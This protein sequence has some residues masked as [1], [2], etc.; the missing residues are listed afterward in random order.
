MSLLLED[1][2]KFAMG[3]TK[4]PIPYQ[5]LHISLSSSS[6]FA[7]LFAT[8]RQDGRKVTVT[9]LRSA[10]QE[11]RLTLWIGARHTDVRHYWFFLREGIELNKIPRNF[12]VS[13]S[14]EKS[15]DFT[16]KNSTKSQCHNFDHFISQEKFQQLRIFQIW[17]WPLHF[18]RN[19]E[20]KS[21]H[22]SFWTKSWVLLQ[23]AKHRH[24][25]RQRA[26][27]LEIMKRVCKA[28]AVAFFCHKNS[29]GNLSKKIS[30][31]W[32]SLYLFIAFEI[33][34]AT[35]FAGNF[36]QMRVFPNTV[37]RPWSLSFLLA[38]GTMQFP[39]SPDAVFVH[40]FN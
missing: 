9:L 2:N 4:I 22:H 12:T 25:R 30:Y 8:K 36:S 18:A 34:Q 15:V 32:R 28:A 29:V 7:A 26:S 20:I 27:P 39:L 33:E 5:F 35:N 17:A 3:K 14:Q 23:C 13:I 40:F 24:W 16:L 37:S 31:L 10:N 19:S 21:C 11:R 6:I 38:L 1:K